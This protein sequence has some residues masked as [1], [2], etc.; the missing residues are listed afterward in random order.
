M[1]LLSNFKTYKFED[2]REMAKTENMGF[3]VERLEFGHFGNFDFITPESINRLKLA[4][5]DIYFGYTVAMV[6]RLWAHLP[7]Y[8]DLI[9]AWH[10]S[11]F[12]K[13]WEWRITADFL[14]V[15]EQNQVIAS[16]NFNFDTGP[17]KLGMSNFGGMILLWLLGMAVSVLV[18]GGELLVYKMIQKKLKQRQAENEMYNRTFSVQEIF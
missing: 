13:I 17:V 15:N 7:I 8:N 18:F 5:D 10:S 2:V 16:R 6:S 4:L 9:L 11:G 1:R 14:N 12:D 3:A